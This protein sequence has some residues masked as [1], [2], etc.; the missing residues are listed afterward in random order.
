MRGRVLG[1]LAVTIGTG[2]VSALGIGLLADRYGHE[3]ALHPRDELRSLVGSDAYYFGVSHPGCA[4]LHPLKYA[5][6]LAG[7]ARR[8]GARIYE[9]TEATSVETGRVRTA[10]GES[11]AGRAD[12]RSRGRGGLL[13]MSGSGRSRDVPT[14]TSSANRPPRRWAGW[15]ALATLTSGVAAGC[16]YD[17]PLDARP[18]PCGPGWTCDEELGLCVDCGC[19]DL[20]RATDEEKADEQ[21]LLCRCDEIYEH[22]TKPAA[23]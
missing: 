14:T 17:I 2:P 7:A 1:V 22:T 13:L 11:S 20:A 9:M 19:I 10:R 16:A 23:K 5:M 6:G 21:H 8:A 12:D 3:T 4:H 18:C 15:L